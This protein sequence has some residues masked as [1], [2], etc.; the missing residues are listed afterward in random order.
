M[1]A[2]NQ[3]ERLSKTEARRWFLAGF[4]EGEGSLCVSIKSHPTCRS[5]FYVDPEFFIYQHKSGVELLEIA[6]NEFGTGRIYPKVGNEDVLVFAITSRRSL[7]E[8]V[9][10]FFEKYMIFS[11]KKDTYIKWKE[12]V[13]A[14]EERKEHRTPQGLARL[15]EKAYELNPS[16]K[17]KTRK[18]ELKEVLDRIL[19]GHTPDST[20]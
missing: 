17:G 16:G 15:V 9:I 7:Y 14:M 18:R 12:I 3:Q 8:K 2:A 20:D 13:I 6:K 11:T 10:P 5:R 19:R 4:I 1:S